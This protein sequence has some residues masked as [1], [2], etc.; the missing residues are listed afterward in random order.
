MSESTED[1]LSGLYLKLC[2][3]GA[4]IDPKSPPAGQADKQKPLG[5]PLLTEGFPVGAEARQASALPLSYVP[6][7]PVWLV[8]V[9][10]A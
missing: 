5:K 8:M 6:V 3:P 10:G 4:V 7:I 9:P 1:R 2:P